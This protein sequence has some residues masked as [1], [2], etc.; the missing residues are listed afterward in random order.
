MQYVTWNVVG[1]IGYITLNRPDKRNALN[2]QVVSELKECVSHAE[3]DT[4]CKI[5]VLQSNGPAFCAGADLDYIKQLRDNT[6][7]ENLQDSAHLMDLFRMIYTHP[8][9]FISKVNGPALAGGCGLATVTDFCFA[10]EGST[11]GYTEAKIGFVPAIVMVFLLRKIGEGRTREI[12]LRANIFDANKAMAYGMVNEVVKADELDDEVRTFAQKLINSNSKQ[13]M[14]AIKRMLTEVPEKTF[15]G[16][17]EYAAAF[18]AEM[19]A[20]EDCKR[21]INAFLN[22]E[23]ISWD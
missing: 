16:A 4:S 11:F 17:L 5:V 9:V 6:F 7:D 21:G 15:T 3:H 2:A 14:A 10:S 20:T 12:M 13:S 19:R 22:K 1:G 18:N 23:K 8:K